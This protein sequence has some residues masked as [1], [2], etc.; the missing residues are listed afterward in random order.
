[1]VIKEYGQN[2]NRRIVLSVKYES[3]VTMGHIT[4]ENS[5]YKVMINLDGIELGS[6]NLEYLIKEI[7]LANWN[8]YNFDVGEKLYYLDGSDSVTCISV[9]NVNGI[10]VFEK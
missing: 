9:D 8:W 3:E 1:M 5:N 6:G 10:I 4:I 7:A 2:A